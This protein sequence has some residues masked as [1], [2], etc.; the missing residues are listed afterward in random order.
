MAPHVDMRTL[1][2]PRLRFRD[3]SLDD[4]PVLSDF[5]AQPEEAR[6]IGGS[7]APEATW[8]LMATYQGH[9]HWF[10]YSYLAMERRDTG[11]LVGTVGLWN[12]APWPEPELGYWLLP[13]ARG[14]GFGL[15]AGRS[16][17]EFAKERAR[18]PSLVS[19]IDSSNSP[20]QRLAAGLGAEQDG[21]IELLTFGPHQVW[22]YW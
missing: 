18:L 20:S 14:Q 22:R 5:F 3:W 21:T 8:R 17:L 9:F 10:G 16:A 11:R 4:F 13:D 15:E 1:E 19:Y 12:S 6:Y 7:R 2:T